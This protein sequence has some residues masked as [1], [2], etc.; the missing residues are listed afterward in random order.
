MVR[1]ASA[2]RPLE[3][4]EEWSDVVPQDLQE[5]FQYRKGRQGLRSSVHYW[6]SLLRDQWPIGNWIN[7]VEVTLPCVKGCTISGLLQEK[8]C[9]APLPIMPWL[10]YTQFPWRFANTLWHYIQ[11][12][13]SRVVSC[14]CFLIV[15]IDSTAMA[16]PVPMQRVWM[17]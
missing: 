17:H 9:I 15:N 4:A 10:S 8:L 14:F 6:M 13:S 7:S 5:L 3:F 11:W 12:H 16:P 2:Q 1:D